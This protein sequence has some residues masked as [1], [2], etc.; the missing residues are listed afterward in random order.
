V[1][2]TTLAGCSRWEA[3]GFWVIELTGE[4]AAA[5]KF[6]LSSV[7]PNPFNAAARVSFSLDQAGPARLSLYDLAGRLMWDSSLKDFTV[8][9]NSLSIDASVLPSGIYFLQLDCRDQS[10]RMKLVLM[11]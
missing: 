11:R 1:E 4:T 3:D 5:V 6:G 8:G 10:D 7:Y 2:H 9:S